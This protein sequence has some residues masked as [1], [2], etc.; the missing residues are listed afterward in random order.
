MRIQGGGLLTSHCYR[1]PSV[2]CS[3]RAHQSTRVGGARAAGAWPG[4]AAGR[5]RPAARPTP[6]PAC[7]AL[8][9]GRMVSA[10]GGPSMQ[11]EMT[12]SPRSSTSP[13]TRR[14]SRCAPRGAPQQQARRGTSQQHARRGTS[15][16]YARPASRRRAV[17]WRVSC[18]W[19][20]VRTGEQW[21]KGKLR[22][23]SRALLAGPQG[24]LGQARA[25]RAA[26][27]LLRPALLG[28]QRAVLLGVAQDQVH[29][30]VKGHEP[31][32]AAPRR[33]RA[34]AHN[35]ARVPHACS[36]RKSCEHMRP[37][38]QDGA[39]TCPPCGAHL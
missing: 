32:R 35:Q 10:G 4:A 29:V 22:C 28:R 25:G 13:S 23:R 16:Q 26:H 21:Q 19:R 38:L 9:A 2:L 27:V 12:S 7:A 1:K 17:R 3:L 33:P 30:A 39:H 18:C 24:G 37:G 8:L 5:P 36:R 15:C 31:A 14:C 6:G 34:P 20:A 11:M